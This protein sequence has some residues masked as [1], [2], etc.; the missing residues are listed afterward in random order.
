[1][2]RSA[3]T[4]SKAVAKRMLAEHQQRDL[5]GDV[6]HTVVEAMDRFRVKYLSLLKP[7]T[8]VRHEV[9]FRQMPRFEGLYLDEISRAALAD[10]AY[11]R[12][13]AGVNPATIRRDLNTFSGVLT[14]AVAW[15][16]ADQNPLWKLSKRHL[17][18]V[19]VFLS[20]AAT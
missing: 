5:N 1:M 2:R 16:W 11:K 20:V 14:R 10:Y 13:R 4:T 7:T 17:A 12:L 6:R 8:R 18:A 3:R 15:D 19:T 9:S